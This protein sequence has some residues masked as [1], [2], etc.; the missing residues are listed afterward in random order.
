MTNFAVIVSTKDPAGMN[1]K[2]NLLNLFSFKK[3]NERYDNHGIFV[4]DKIKL[5]TTDTDSV[6]CEN[7]DKNIN[8]DVFIFAT[9]HQSASGVHSLSVHSPGNWGKAEFGG[10]DRHICV[11]PADYLMA[12]LLKLKEF[13]ESENISYEIIEEC[14]HH[15]PYLEKPV[16]FIEIGSNL[17]SWQNKKAGSIIAK[18]IYYICTENIEK[19]K[20]ILGIG[21]IH[22]TPVLTSYAIKNNLAIS[23]VCPKYNLQNLDEQMVSQA[24][25]KPNVD[26]VILDWKGMGNQKDRILSLLEK[27]NIKFEKTK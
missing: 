16:M 2:D 26:L 21:G 12:A 7:I 20:I 19:R 15:G 3:T 22:H 27:M 4:L 23:H 24:M 25:T 17:E 13:K 10:K 6:C 11:A 1:I 5:C 18:T 8:A 9:K 14:T